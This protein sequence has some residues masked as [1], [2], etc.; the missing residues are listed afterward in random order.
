MDFADQIKLLFTLAF[1][2]WIVAFVVA[3]RPYMIAFSGSPDKRLP[4]VIGSIWLGISTLLEMGFYAGT[5]WF[6][7]RD[8]TIW[9]LR[10]IPTA[11]IT[12]AI[13]YIAIGLWA[14]RA[15]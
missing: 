1:A 2:L 10:L 12:Q 7:W 15:V 9:A 4:F 5:I 3:T 8:G 11:A 13:V 6:E 14:R